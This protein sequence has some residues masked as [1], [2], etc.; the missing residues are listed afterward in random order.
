[1]FCILCSLT[2]TDLFC[3][4]S[5]DRCCI[6]IGRALHRLCM[7]RPWK[8]VTDL[9]LS[10][11][12]SVLLVG[13]SFGAPAAFLSTIL[14]TFTRLSYRLLCWRDK[15]MYLTSEEEAEGLQKKVPK[16]HDVGLRDWN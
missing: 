13:I 4:G 15:W 6:L 2:S 16:Y 12:T 7:S 10:H 1:M 11:P 9:R 5:L 8:D 3:D 14:L